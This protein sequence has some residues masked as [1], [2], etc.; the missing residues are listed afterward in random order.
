[1]NNLL[2]ILIIGTLISILISIIASYILSKKAL[3]P[4]LSSWKKQIEFTANAS[5][6]LRSPL[7]VMQ[8]KQEQL[9]KEPNATILEKADNVNMTL[10]EI[11]RMTKL[12]T[13]LMTL[14]RADSNTQVLNKEKVNIDELIEN[15]AK[16]YIELAESQEKKLELN[17]NFKKNLDIDVSKFKQLMVILLDNAIKYT[18]AGNL[19]N[20]ETHTKDNHFILELKDTGIGISE[21]GRKHIFDRFYRED[22]ARSRE[23][24][25]TGLRTF[26]CVLDCNCTWRHNKSTQK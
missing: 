14:A 26:Y 16:P 13:D 17:L 9:L 19:I 6:E 8:L 23:N 20:I 18:E 7:T 21:E 12:T 5:H 24:R 4:V 3:I 2:D 10:D 22:K 1:M 11:E 15:I 25:G